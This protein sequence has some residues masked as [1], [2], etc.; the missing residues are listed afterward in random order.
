[1]ET[2]ITSASE[3]KS[4]GNGKFAGFL[5]RFSDENQPDLAGDFFTAE[6]DF[7][8]EPGEVKKSPVYYNHGLD[9]TL[10][11]R[12]IGTAELTLQDAGVWMEGQIVKA[13]AYNDSVI[14]LIEANRCGSSSGTAS[15]L[16]EREP[17]GKAF[18]IKSWPLGLDASITVEPCDPFNHVVSI[19]SIEG[20]LKSIPDLL[21]EIEAGEQT[22]AEVKTAEPV[23]DAE[24]DAH[25][26]QSVVAIL[27]AMNLKTYLETMGAVV[28]DTDR[29]LT[30][31]VEQR[32]IKQGRAISADNL[33]A[34][35]GI[36]D[37]MDSC[38]ETLNDH[39]KKLRAMVD[40]HTKPAGSDNTPPFNAVAREFTRYLA[41]NSQGAGASMTL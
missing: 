34:M 9:P 22:P 33:S 30:W 12:K 20:N 23:E 1:M 26:P 16:V 36:C 5:V 39:R 29:R 27:T 25:T 21:R 40:A 18:H 2:L 24:E 8:L 17:S 14:K 37:G 15:H 3:I 28:S 41:L 32:A 4:L 6:T 10:K 7:G 38:V 13:D 11:T 35:A 19:K 31:Y